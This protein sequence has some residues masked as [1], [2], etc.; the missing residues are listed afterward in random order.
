MTT[1]PVRPETALGTDESPAARCPYCNRPFTSERACALHLGGVHRDEWTEAERAT[2]ERAWDDES[3]DLFVFHLK[4]VA[5]L[6]LLY[7]VVVLV[8]MVVLGLQT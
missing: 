1:E 8:Y 5:T 2:Y 3:D 6:T 4:V 7:A